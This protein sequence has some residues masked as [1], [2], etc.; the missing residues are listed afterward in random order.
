MATNYDFFLKHKS[1]YLELS[2]KISEL[3]RNGDEV[4]KALLLNAITV[5]GLADVPDD[6]LNAY[7]S[8]L[9]KRDN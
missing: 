8:D 1:D 9:K 6:E 2:H 5:G 3:R 7:L 4:P